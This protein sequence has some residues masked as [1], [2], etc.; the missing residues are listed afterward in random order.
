M[1][2]RK[3]VYKSEP[4]AWSGPAEPEAVSLSL[5]L[6]G[7]QVS[8]TYEARIPIRGDLRRVRLTLTGK[9]ED[10]SQARVAWSSSEPAAHG[11]ISLKLA[12]DGRLF[13][14][15]LNSSDNY[16]PTGMEVLVPR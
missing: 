9:T 8:G 16:V 12:A 5:H 7:G 13:V 2:G 10:S 6:G 1:D 14:Q 11:E 4:G 15:V 3:W